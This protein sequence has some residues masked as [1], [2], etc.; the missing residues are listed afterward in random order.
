LL[1]WGLDYPPLTAYV[2][3]F[4]GK[5]A[6]ATEPAW[7]ALND[8]HGIE[9]MQLK[10]FMRSTVIFCDLL[11]FL[12]ALFLAL[13]G[14]RIAQLIAVRLDSF[15]VAANLTD[16]QSISSSYRPRALPVQQRV[17]GPRIARLCLHHSRP[18]LSRQL[19]LCGCAVF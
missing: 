12:P 3:Y 18:T 10:M 14:R 15:V 17:S 5:V 2:S 19:L 13:R 11:V 16:Y 1:Y 9:S 8:S 7:V 4:F 6:A